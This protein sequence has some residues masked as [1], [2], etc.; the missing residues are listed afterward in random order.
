VEVPISLPGV[1]PVVLDP[2]QA[3]S[4]AGAY[5]QMAEKLVQLFKNNF[6]SFQDAQ[7]FAIFGP[8]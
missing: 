3:W 4:D 1:D 6:R 8:R 7:E 5:R 2:S